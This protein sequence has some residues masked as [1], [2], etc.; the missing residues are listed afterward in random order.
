MACYERECPVCEYEDCKCQEI[1]ELEYE[2]TQEATDAE[3]D[4][5]ADAYEQSIGY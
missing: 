3:Y 5:I 2:E 1:A 4:A